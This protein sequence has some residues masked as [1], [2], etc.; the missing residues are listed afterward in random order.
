[1]S[2]KFVASTV[3]TAKDMTK[4]VFA[5]MAKN[6]KAAEQSMRS[7]RKAGESLG[8]A[9][10][11]LSAGITA[12]VVGLGANAL[13]MAT[14][15]SASM[16]NV[17]AKLLATGDEMTG[18]R[19]KAKEL[20]SSTSFSAKQAADA[21]GF[22][23][24]AGFKT[25]QILS[26]VP[27]V[28]NLA[29]AA[30]MD[31]AR[32]SDIASDVMGQ[33]G[34]EADKQGK[35]ITRVAD[36]LANASAKSNLSVEQMFESLKQAGPFAK[37]YGVTIEETAAALGK[38]ADSGIKGSQ[39]GMVLKTVFTNLSKP[40]GEGKKALGELGL[41][42]SDFF[43]K[44]AEGKLELTGIANAMDKLTK[45]GASNA[46]LTSI[47]GKEAAAGILILK[48]AGGGIDELADKLQESGVAAR[49][50]KIQIQ[51]LPG[52]MASMR[53]VWEGLNIA[54]AES[55]AFK[56]L[57]EGFKSV[58]KSMQDMAKADPEKFKTI[59][60]AAAGAAII[61][62]GLILLGA[63]MT[64][65]ASTVKVAA[66]ALSLFKVASLPMLA[67]VAAIAGAATLIYKNWDGITA[68]F[69]GVA[70][71]AK[72]SFDDIL[73]SI[74]P[75]TDALSGIARSIKN[76]FSGGE[77]TKEQFMQAAEGVDNLH[78]S[79]KR[80]GEIF[81]KLSP[82]INSAVVAL[83][84][85]FIA[86]K[87]AETVSGMTGAFKA[88]ATIARAHPVLLLIS[89]IAAG[90]VYIYRNWDG[91]SKWFSDTWQAIKQVFSDGVSAVK[92][93][94]LNFTAVG[95]V[96]K[97][98]DSIG[99]WFGAKWE[100]VKTFFS[101]GIGGVI[102]SLVS[103]NPQSLL[104]NVWLN[105]ARWFIQKWDEIKS[106][107][108][109]GVDKITA[110]LLT[111]T[112]AELVYKA[113]SGLS[114]WFDGIWTD[115]KNTV[116][117]KLGEIGDMLRNFNPVD[118]ISNIG[119]GIK[120]GLTDAASKILGRKPDPAVVEQAGR[121]IYKHQAA[122]IKQS[123]IGQTSFTKIPSLSDIPSLQ[124]LDSR[125]MEG[126]VNAE[127]SVRVESSEGLQVR[128][129]GVETRQSGS[130]MR[131]VGVSMVAE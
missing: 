50:A 12:P 61:G 96:Y 58:T 91:I 63:S 8:S 92:N 76:L 101:D 106:S 122:P 79:G 66:G 49:M 25:N 47:F 117:R 51:G 126:S 68:F 83:G 77:Q 125:A 38:M 34:F 16:N 19:D 6:A 65:L 93:Y 90:A 60:T 28:L 29:S 84:G 14:D 13:R 43:K 109:G 89:G 1:M 71:G 70:E 103:F 82:L 53:S 46:Q 118:F 74:K 75:A 87:V 107:F 105:A 64:G 59:L 88:L 52:V 85:L 97:N 18:L 39:A 116:S 4:G 113:W 3:L 95:L 112:P 10:R 27:I 24:Q 20:G 31:L 9:G 119:S 5:N 73:A 123:D 56:P 22:L 21:M 102:A 86:K 62:P 128:N 17:Q 15:F 111:F 36:V 127:I 104:F 114:A 81:K 40:V 130:L 80:V 100:S 32:A 45:A 54:A 108:S 115:A 42:L 41:T 78:E 48:E 72:G 69:R 23:A 129:S 11:T 99:P 131:P 98:W 7:V 120:Q 30:Q 55:G 110:L 33:F 2:I 44:N 26:S 37:A 57:I 35:N 124:A 121:V 67:A 94:L